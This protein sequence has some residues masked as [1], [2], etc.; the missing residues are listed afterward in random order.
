MY[1]NIVV[2]A[3][4]VHIW[5]H[6]VSSGVP[7][8]TIATKTRVFDPD[9]VVPPSSTALERPSTS[10]S[11]AGQWVKVGTTVEALFLMLILMG[12]VKRI[13][14]AMVRVGFLLRSGLKDSC[15][16][17]TQILNNGE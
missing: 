15:M 10:H 6:R 5:V 9:A 11:V 12:L 16:A 7:P 13:V 3:I 17:C 2:S 8:T 1:V 4:R 14:Q